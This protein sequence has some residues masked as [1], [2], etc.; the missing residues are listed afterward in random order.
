MELIK[1]FARALVAEAVAKAPGQFIRAGPQAPPGYR[2]D[3]VVVYALRVD[4]VMPGAEVGDT[5]LYAR[6]K[7]AD[8]GKLIVIRSGDGRLQTS[9]TGP[10]GQPPHGLVIAVLNDRS[11]EQ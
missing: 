10:R 1:A 3:E 4:W 2:P 8:P 11:P 5:L 9:R 6:E 7:V